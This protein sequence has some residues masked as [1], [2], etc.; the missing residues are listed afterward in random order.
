VF[1]IKIADKKLKPYEKTIN[2]QNLSCSE[3]E[4]K[5]NTI[6]EKR[7]RGKRRL[8]LYY[9]MHS[10]AIERAQVRAKK[11]VPRNC[12][13]WLLEQWCCSFRFVRLKGFGRPSVAA[14]SIRE[15]RKYPIV[16]R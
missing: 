13:N 6:L 2:I 7:E 9:H 16:D 11:R 5:T 1:Q 12:S 4:Q 15:R 10:Y 3:S 8:V 14:Q